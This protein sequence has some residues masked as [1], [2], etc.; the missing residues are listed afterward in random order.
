MEERGEECNT[1]GLKTL[2]YISNIKDTLVEDRRGK[3]G[4]KDSRFKDNMA[5]WRRVGG[6]ERG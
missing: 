4:V 5:D 3:G 1:T 2:V 6:R